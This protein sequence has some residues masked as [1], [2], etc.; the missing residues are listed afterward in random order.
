MTHRLNFWR[1]SKDLFYNYYEWEIYVSSP[2][3]L[4]FNWNQITF[5]LITVLLYCMNKGQLLI[6]LLLNML[7]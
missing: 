3:C 4:I 5:E 7:S 2:I 1:G 6:F